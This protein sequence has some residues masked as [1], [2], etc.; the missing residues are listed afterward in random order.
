[1]IANTASHGPT[2]HHFQP[3][4]LYFGGQLAKVEIAADQ[5]FDDGGG[6]HQLLAIAGHGAGEDI[7]DHD[8]RNG[9]DQPMA[10]ASSASAMPGATT[11]R[12]VVCACEMPIKEFMMPQTVPNRP[13][14]GANGADGRQHARAAG[15]R[16]PARTSRRVSAEVTR[17]LTPSLPA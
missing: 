16:R 3:G 13:T 12:L 8:G 15:H 11:A 5:P 9:R 7:I 2:R 6:I 1:M 4:G 10:V 14:K 17:S